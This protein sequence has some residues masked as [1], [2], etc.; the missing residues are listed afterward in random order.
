MAKIQTHGKQ[1]VSTALCS[2]HSEMLLGGMVEGSSSPWLGSSSN[3]YT[4]LLNST[5]IIGGRLVSGY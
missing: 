1:R 2:V 3:L 4:K 5:I